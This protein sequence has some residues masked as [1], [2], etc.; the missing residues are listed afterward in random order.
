M[1]LD[2]K[3]G[4]TDKKVQEKIR[5][6]GGVSQID[7]PLHDLIVPLANERLYEDNSKIVR[8]LRKDHRSNDHTNWL[9]RV[10]QKE[11]QRK[12]IGNIAE[13]IEFE[14]LVKAGAREYQAFTGEKVGYNLEEI[15][16]DR[17]DQ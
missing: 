12:T 2:Y 11:P 15:Q 1:A 17:G 8:E 13:R 4:R 6:K 10:P 3:L 14:E 9:E 16:I 5:D 7:S